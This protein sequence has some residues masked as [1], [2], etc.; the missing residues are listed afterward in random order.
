[1]PLEAELEHL[2]KYL[3]IEKL[4]FGKKLN[5]EYDIQATDFKVPL[6][7]IQPLV[8]NAVKHGVGIKKKGGTVTISS[9][10][11]DNGITIPFKYSDGFFAADP[12]QFD[13]HLATMSDAMAEASTT[14]VNNGDWSDGA[15]A[16]KEVLGKCGFE[17]VEESSSYKVKPT[18]DSVACATKLIM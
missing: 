8:E 11:T 18:E 15:K 14:Y 17:N 13:N 5:V 1:V 2:K 6:L 16:I 4:R 7:S 3:Y 9:K 12:T 10:Q